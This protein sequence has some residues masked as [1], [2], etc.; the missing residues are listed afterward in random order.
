LLVT[1]LIVAS[2]G[3]VCLNFIVQQQKE[4]RYSC[5]A[6]SLVYEIPRSSMSLHTFCATPTFL[7]KYPHFNSYFYFKANTYFFKRL[8][9]RILRWVK[10]LIGKVHAVIQSAI[11]DYWLR[12]NSLNFNIKILYIKDIFHKSISIKKD[13][14][15]KIIKYPIY[16]TS[17]LRWC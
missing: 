3:N 8:L 4:D 6:F 5:K 1:P 9:T 11:C 12:L 7:Y 2:C 10:V 13:S 14:F 17:C 15:Y 16:K